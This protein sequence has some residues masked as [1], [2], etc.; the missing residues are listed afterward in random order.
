MEE[1][2]MIRLCAAA[3]AIAISTATDKADIMLVPADGSVGET[4]DRL[5]AA[6]K[7]AGATV[8]ARIDHGAGA[9]SVDMDLADSELVVFG[10]PKLGTPALQQDIQAGLVLP[11]RVLIYEDGD[12][13]TWLAYED[14]DALFEGFKISE[15]AAF[16]AAIAG[17][18]EKLTAAA[19]G[20]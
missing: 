3:L 11:L 8:F 6:V 20:D 14:V 10:N 2:R 12:A 19:A 4:A 5:E 16:R 1:D 7:N 9:A 13:K 17:A 18:L 15:D